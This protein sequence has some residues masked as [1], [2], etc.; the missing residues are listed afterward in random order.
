MGNNLLFLLSVAAKLVFLGLDRAEAL[1]QTYFKTYTIEQIESM[2]R[3][4][5]ET[6]RLLE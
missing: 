1:Q 2:L 4:A 3:P 5:T 6:M